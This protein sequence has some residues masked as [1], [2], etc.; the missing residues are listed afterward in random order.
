MEEVEMVVV[1]VVAVEVFG[2]VGNDACL[3]TGVTILSAEEDGVKNLAADI[4]VEDL[5][6][7]NASRSAGAVA[8]VSVTV[9]VAATVV[10]PGVDHN[11]VSPLLSAAAVA[12][13]IGDDTFPDTSYCC[14]WWSL[15]SAGI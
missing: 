14:C 11:E 5:R 6:K 7:S 4:F 1:E 15:L 8:L 9:A 3:L 10:V 12:A 13:E 2:V